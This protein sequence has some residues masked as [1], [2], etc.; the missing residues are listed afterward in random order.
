MPTNP[1]LFTGS[2]LSREAYIAVVTGTVLAAEMS[3]DITQRPYKV[4]SHHTSTKLLVQATI[5]DLDL[6][7]YAGEGGVGKIVEGG[8]EEVALAWVHRN[9]LRGQDWKD[10]GN[11]SCA[12]VHVC[13]LIRHVSV[14]V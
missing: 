11:S 5:G 3:H 12:Q 13:I 10:H 9:S 4:M 7:W 8:G 6:S 14:H 1:Y 2:T